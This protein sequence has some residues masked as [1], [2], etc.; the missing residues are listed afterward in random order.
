MKRV[1][2]IS[3]LSTLALGAAPV[4]AKGGHGNDEQGAQMRESNRAT[5]AQPGHGE[6]ITLPATPG[7]EKAQ[8][9]TSEHRKSHKTRKSKKERKEKRKRQQ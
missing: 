1:L 3:I 8:S 2:A 4:M 7:N 9:N 5:P 6:E